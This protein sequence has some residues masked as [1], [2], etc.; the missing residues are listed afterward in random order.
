MFGESSIWRVFPFR[1]WRKLKEIL[2]TSPVF[3]DSDLSVITRNLII[4]IIDYTFNPMNSW[5]RWQSIRCRSQLSICLPNVWHLNWDPKEFESI[6][7]SKCQII[8]RLY[9][10]PISLFLNKPCFNPDAYIWKVWFRCLHFGRSGSHEWEVLPFGKNRRKYW[11]RQSC[12]ISG[13]RR[14]ILRLRN[15]S[16]CGRRVSL[17]EYDEP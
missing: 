14:R 13:L 12:R 7:L 16:S 6:V 5:F 11:L 15:S 9:K 3:V 8:W 10:L 4:H 17:R 1:I 2:L